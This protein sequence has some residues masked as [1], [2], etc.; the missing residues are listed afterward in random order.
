MTKFETIG[1]Q[2]QMDAE[3]P[4]DAVRKFSYSCRVC[5]SRG[6]RIECDRC[7]IRATHEST[8]AWMKDQQEESLRQPIADLI[9]RKV[10]AL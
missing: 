3:T 6:L 8:V 9:S 2:L 4:R 7:A 10:S 5:S 1:V